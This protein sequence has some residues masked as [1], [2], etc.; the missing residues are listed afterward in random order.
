MCSIAPLL[1]K[2]KVTTATSPTLLRWNGPA[3]A[4][5][6]RRGAQFHEDG[7]LQD[8]LIDHGLDALRRFACQ[9]CYGFSTGVVVEHRQSFGTESGEPWIR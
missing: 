6:S 9:S 7:E 2:D 8:L 1:Q 4:N 3:C 5:T